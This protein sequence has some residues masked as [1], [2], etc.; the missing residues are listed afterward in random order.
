[1]MTIF[2]VIQTRPFG[3]S[4]RGGGGERRAERGDGE[5][6]GEGRTKNMMAEQTSDRPE[7][8]REHSPS[9]LKVR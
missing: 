1:M 3:R 8:R 9:P 4:G 2:D 7:N 6:G 5:V